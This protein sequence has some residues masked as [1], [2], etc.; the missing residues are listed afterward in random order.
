VPGPGLPIS[1]T[2]IRRRLREGKSVRYL[3]SDAVAE[4]IAKRRLFT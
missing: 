1:A 2:D 3:V 4:Y